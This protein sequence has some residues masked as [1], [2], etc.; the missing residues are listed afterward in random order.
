MPDT[1]IRL[2]PTTIALLAVAC[3]RKEP[4]RAAVARVGLPAGVMGCYTLLRSHESASLGRTLSFRLDS[5]PALSKHPG[6]HPARSLRANAREFMSF[7]SA[8][9]LTDTIGVSIGDGFTGVLISAV[10]SHGR[11][12]GRARAFSDYGPTELELGDVE[13]VSRPCSDGQQTTERGTAARTTAMPR[14]DRLAVIVARSK[15][16]AYLA[17]PLAAAL[18]YTQPSR[19]A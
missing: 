4:D 9:S 18:R 8:D 19:N 12:R 6:L 14:V 5:L 16:G 15:R 11:L 2:L 1:R 13:Y 17:G 10:P 3:V 7:W